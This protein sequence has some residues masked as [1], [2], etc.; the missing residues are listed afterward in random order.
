VLLESVVISRDLCKCFIVVSALGAVQTFV[1]LACILSFSHRKPLY[2][3][4]TILY[5]IRSERG[6]LHFAWEH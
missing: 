1:F 6:Y 3:W 4:A 2:V 5:S